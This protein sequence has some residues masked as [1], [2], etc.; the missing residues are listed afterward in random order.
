MASKQAVSG[1]RT[2]S[3]DPV[4]HHYWTGSIWIA[5]SALILASHYILRLTGNRKR[6][7]FL[8][9]K[10]GSPPRELYFTMLF[11][12]NSIFSVYTSTKLKLGGSSPLVITPSEDVYVFLEKADRMRVLRPQLMSA[13]RLMNVGSRIVLGTQISLFNFVLSGWKR[14]DSIRTSSGA[15]WRTL[16]TKQAHRRTIWTNNSNQP[17][18]RAGQTRSTKDL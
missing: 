1:D 5:W 10:S 4:T 6:G 3:T 18:V 8:L 11:F 7:Y 13:K 2:W 17:I 14:E 12:W 16:R 9:I 15:R